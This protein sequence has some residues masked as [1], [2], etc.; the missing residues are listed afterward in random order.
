MAASVSAH[1]SISE[2]NFQGLEKQK[3]GREIPD[4]PA[5]APERRA[6]FGN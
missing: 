5:A 3:D 4:H 1:W 6:Y 2:E